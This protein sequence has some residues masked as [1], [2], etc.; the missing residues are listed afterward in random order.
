MLGFGCILGPPIC[1]HSVNK[2]TSSWW[3]VLRCETLQVSIA[4]WR[5]FGIVEHPPQKSML[6]SI[7]AEFIEAT[8]AM[9]GSPNE[10]R[11]IHMRSRSS[12]QQIG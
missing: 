12:K 2:F 1:N 8:L 11:Y 7:S 5:I 9:K 3:L 10:A 4:R 6:G